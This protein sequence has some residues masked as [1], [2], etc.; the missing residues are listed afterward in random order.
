MYY[1]TK[2]TKLPQTKN[3]NAKKTEGKK[4]DSFLFRKRSKTDWIQNTLRAVKNTE[5]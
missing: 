3:N 5:F 2:L 4:F 1:L